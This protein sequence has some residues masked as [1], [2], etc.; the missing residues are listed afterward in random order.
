MSEKY[1]TTKEVAK[2]FRKTPQTVR[3][4][5]KE[6][7]IEAVRV[8]GRILIP[9][10][11]LESIKQPVSSTNQI[12]ET[13]NSSNLL[14]WGM[15]S[16]NRRNF[17]V[18]FAA[19]LVSGVMILATDRALGGLERKRR[20]KKALLLKE[21]KAKELFGEIFGVP[22]EIRSFYEGTHPDNLAAGRALAPI[23]GML[24]S[25]PIQIPKSNRLK[26]L[27]EGDFVLIGGPN[28]TPLTKIVWEFDGPNDRELDRAPIPVLPLRFYGVSNVKDS[29]LPQ[30]PI[31]WRLEGVGPVTT[32]NWPFVDMK[33]NEE[34]II[35][36]PGSR[37]EVKGKKAYLPYDNYILVTKLPNFLSPTRQGYPR[38]W[39]QLLVFEGNNGVGTRAAELLIQPAGIE[40][41]EH[42]KSKLY[43]ATSFQALFR[44]YDLDLTDKG[45][46]RF[47][48]IEPLDWAIE[49]LEISNLVFERAHKESIRRFL[50]ENTT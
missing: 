5:A 7:R 36:Q 39:P 31:G 30:E 6:G 23:L 19:S 13:E 41:L 35:P 8:G 44:V 46:H 28:S 1:Y 49:P 38:L 26:I 11:A 14:D 17:I 33:Q 43:G 20:Q 48:K 22:A 40:A 18:S 3:R 4:W 12:E 25:E 9:A 34:L 45:Y 21:E 47:S 27:P 29:R 2:L 24:D 10:K 32:V 16:M 15:A 42:L 37:I 50:R